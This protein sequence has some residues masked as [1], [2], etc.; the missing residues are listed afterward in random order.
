MSSSETVLPAS[1]RPMP[2]PPQPERI[3]P[4]TADEIEQELQE[5]TDRLARRVDALVGRMSPKR[6]ANRSRA[7]VRGAFITPHGRPRPEVVGAAIGGLIGVAVL[8]WWAR[9]RD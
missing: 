8:V 4:R 5:T 6:V 9:R 7:A 1:R 2:G 3:P